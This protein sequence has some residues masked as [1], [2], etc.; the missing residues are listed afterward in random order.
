MSCPYV[1]RESLGFGRVREH[2]YYQLD[3]LVYDLTHDFKD[4]DVEIIATPLYDVTMENGEEL[5]QLDDETVF[6]MLSVGLPIKFVT[7]ARDGYIMYKRPERKPVIKVGGITRASATV[8]GVRQYDTAIIIPMP[9]EWQVVTHS[10]IPTRIYYTMFEQYAV[11]RF[12]NA[13]S[14][15]WG[16]VPFYDEVRLYHDGIVVRAGVNGKEITL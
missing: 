15:K 3:E 10:D 9:K 11:R 4:A 12:E 13:I 2:G 7:S 6:K 5:S 14:S 1:I 16:C 8:H